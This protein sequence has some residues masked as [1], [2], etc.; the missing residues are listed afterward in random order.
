MKVIYIVSTVLFTLTLIIMTLF[1]T[2]YL[3]VFFI[4]AIG[5]SVL[6]SFI[7]PKEMTANISSKNYVITRI[8]LLLFTLGLWFLL[9][10]VEYIV[11]VKDANKWIQTPCTIIKSERRLTSHDD[12][13]NRDYYGYY[14]VYSY[15]VNNIVYKSDRYTENSFPFVPSLA[16]DNAADFA[17]G[18]RTDCY[19]N[20]SN[21]K[22]AI[23]LKPY[24]DTAATT[25][26]CVLFILSICMFVACGIDFS[27]TNFDKVY[28]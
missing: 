5:I 19:V 4:L 6:I 20:P 16:P 9:T 7:L 14:V 17:A 1:E 28:N 22:K 12:E 3:T 11:R 23:M 24:L 15:K 26:Y 25:Y 27:K 21:P 2:G 10:G 13:E 8:S 18:T